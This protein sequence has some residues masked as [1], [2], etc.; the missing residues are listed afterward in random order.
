M[1][2]VPSCMIGSLC[3]NWP[4]PHPGERCDSS[5]TVGG[6]GQETVKRLVEQRCLA[7][8]S[9]MSVRALVVSL[10]GARPG[11]HRRLRSGHPA[12]GRAA[13]TGALADDDRAPAVRRRARAGRG[14]TGHGPWL[15]DDR[16]GHRLRRDP[17]GP[18]RPRPD[19]RGSRVG[20]VRLLGAGA[21]R[22]TAA[23]RG[24]AA[25]RQQRVP[26]STTA[27]PRTTSTGRRTSPVP[28]ATA[29][30]WPSGPTSTSAPSP[31]PS[32]PAPGRWTGRG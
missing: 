13:L 4:A 31:A 6:G 27:S 12:T 26:R 20:P 17:E 23:G 24:H 3:W 16:D 25:G 7:D 29:T 19:Q 22:G 5:S 11:A 18:G 21:D 28:T 30:S 15:G 14:G 9:A 1:T 10:L 32:R 8:F 2:R